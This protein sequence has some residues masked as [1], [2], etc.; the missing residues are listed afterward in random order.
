MIMYDVRGRLAKRIIGGYRINWSA[1]SRSKLQF[2]VKQLLKVIWSVDV[3]FEEFPVFGS[4]MKI[5]FYNG[6]RKIAVEVNGPQH[7]KVIPFFHGDS[8]TGFVKS[9]KRDLD[10][11][12]WC[13]KNGIRLVE[14]IESD[15]KDLKAFYAMIMNPPAD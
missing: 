15:L 10:K 11:A 7:D 9:V 13:V 2:R 4:R 12:N 3:V 6:T 8:P 1:N 14:V 5:D